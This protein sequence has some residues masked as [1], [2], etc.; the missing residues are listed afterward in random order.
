MRLTRSGHMPVKVSSIGLIYVLPLLVAVL[1]LVMPL[2][3]FSFLVLFILTALV[4]FFR[5][6]WGGYLLVFFIP[7]AGDNIGFHDQGVFFWYNRI[8][9]PFFSVFL[10][11]ELIALGLRKGARIDLFQKKSNPAAIPVTLFSFY[12]LLMLVWKGNILSPVVFSILTINVILFFYI[13]H[14][15]GSSDQVFENIV[16]FFIA[17]GAVSAVL[18]V[19]SVLFHPDMSIREEII[20]KID[21]VFAWL[22]G[23]SR[24]RG[25]S[26]ELSNFT[27]RTLNLTTFVIVGKLLYSS[28]A[29]ETLI[30][31]FLLLLV[32]FANC[33]TSSKGGLGAFLVMM[34]FVILFSSKLNKHVFFNSGLFLAGFVLL[35]ILGILF[36]SLVGD[37]YHATNVVSD[38]GGSIS[39]STRL[40]YWSAGIKMLFRE[41]AFL[42]GLGIGG[43]DY[44]VD[45]GV[46]PHSIYFSFFFDFGMFGLIFLMSLLVVL[47]I[48]SF[49][50][51]LFAS[52]QTRYEHMALCLFAGLLTVGIHGLV[53]FYYNQSIT[54]L[55][56]ALLCAALQ[57]VAEKQNPEVAE[58]EPGEAI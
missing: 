24:N 1:Y 26:F 12:A 53:E 14:L 15:S 39:I 11:L 19:M 43:W 36:V 4:I 13:F 44:F 35:Y 49:N 37:A 50:L 10:L 32:V 34:G 20:A 18:T 17:A 57:K 27:S 25:Y 40:E 2:L 45:L 55:Y 48:Y 52:Q 22:P 33:L 3:S 21:F 9:V 29:K 16:W 31:V 58:P 47:T 54:W 30:L 46:W 42:T 5:P 38:D 28:K 41:D 51:K 7:I 23:K 8:I 6:V 56:L